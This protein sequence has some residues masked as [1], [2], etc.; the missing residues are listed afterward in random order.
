MDSKALLIRRAFGRLTVA[1]LLG[2]ALGVGARYTPYTWPPQVTYPAAFAG[3][4]SFW[5]EN[6][7]G[8]RVAYR[9]CQ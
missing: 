8:S 4:L 6:R 5:V 3:A 9:W 2:L 7:T 1:G